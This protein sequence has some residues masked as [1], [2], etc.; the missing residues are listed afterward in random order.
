[1]VKVLSNV[2]SGN[3]ARTA[4]VASSLS[5][6]SYLCGVFFKQYWRESCL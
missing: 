2:V 1:M 3:S 5:H 6:E 4:N